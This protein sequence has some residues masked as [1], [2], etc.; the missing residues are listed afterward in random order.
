MKTILVLMLI[1][2]FAFAPALAADSKA[3]TLRP[4][5]S[6]AASPTP[7]EA[8]LRKQLEAEYRAALEKRVAQEKA[9]MEGS[10]KSLWMSNAAVWGVLLAFIVLQALG[11]RKRTAELDRL[12]NA[13]EGKGG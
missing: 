2:T 7:T 13:R 3:E 9:S 5:N 12:R 8:E 4:A 6:S 10:L 1:A 11:A